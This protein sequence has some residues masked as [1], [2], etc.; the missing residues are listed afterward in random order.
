[1]RKCHVTTKL[2]QSTPVCIIS[3]ERELISN[4]NVEQVLNAPKETIVEFFSRL[5]Q[6]FKPN[7]VLFESLKINRIFFKPD[8]EHKT[9]RKFFLPRV[10]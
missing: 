1:M 7:Q 10:C 6:R 2:Y 5:R 8:D 3:F 4:R 9:R